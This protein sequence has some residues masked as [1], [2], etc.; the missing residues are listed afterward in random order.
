VG[1]S[2][3]DRLGRASKGLVRQYIAK[4]TGLGRV[5]VSRLI[6]RYL[7]GEEVKALGWWCFRNDTILTRLTR[8]S[9]EIRANDLVLRP[10]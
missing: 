10:D 3:Y 5:Q 2:T 9:H 6:G 1:G 7:A 8:L 4:M